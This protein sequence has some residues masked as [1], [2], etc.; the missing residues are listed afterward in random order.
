M[1]NFGIEG[2]PEHSARYARAE[3]FLDVVKALWNSWDDGALVLDKVS[4]V[5]I[6]EN[7][8]RAIDHV[9]DHFRVAGPGT[10]PR[11]PQAWPVL[12]QAGSSDD[13]LRF[14]ARHA[15]VM[16]TAQP[17]FDPAKA[18]R[19]DVRERVNRVDRDPDLVKVLP[20]LVPILGATEEEAKQRAAE[21]APRDLDVAM[22]QVSLFFGPDV[23]LKRYALDE[24]LPDHLLQSTEA[25]QSRT[26]MLLERA[27]RDKLTLRELV[28]R[29]A[30]GHGHQVLVGS[31]EQVADEMQRW[32]EG[33]AAD[34]FNVQIP[35]LPHDLELFATKVV[36]ILQERGLFRTEYTGTTLR[37]HLGLPRPAQPSSRTR[38]SAA[39]ET[40]SAVG[41]DRG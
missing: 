36:P 10:Q 41:A 31:Y 8:T 11:S 33:G 22:R 20:G 32:F 4:G 18:F 14:A 38:S 28:I 19:D 23:D 26:K 25:H 24:P 9:G 13:G 15:E 3:E 1:A 2:F 5:Y 29:A 12:V 16:F 7:R 39:A 17:A 40:S 37:E 6:D 21:L 27:R 34:G 30:F 35:S